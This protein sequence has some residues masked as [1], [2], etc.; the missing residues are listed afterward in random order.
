MKVKQMRHFILCLALLAPSLPALAGPTAADDGA[1]NPDKVV[2]KKEGETGSL[3]K[4]R[5]T[6]MTVAEWREYYAKA[7]IQ[8]D[9][10]EASRR[11]SSIAI[12]TGQ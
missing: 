5:K 6:C 10:D 1:R 12:P 7:R 9:Q 4:R 2:C 8:A 3:I 11:S